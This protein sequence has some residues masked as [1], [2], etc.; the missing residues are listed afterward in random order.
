MKKTLIALLSILLMAFAFT[1]CDNSN[2]G[3]VDD[4]TVDQATATDLATTYMSAINYGSLIVEAF[5]ESNN[6]LDITPEA[7][8]FTIEFDEYKG[9][10]LDTS[11]KTEEN[12][13][14]L[15][16]IKSGALRFTFP[17]T[18]KATESRT[19]YTVETVEDKPLVF[20]D[21]EN[22][23]LAAFEFSASGTASASFNVVGG[24]IVGIADDATS[25]SISKPTE[26]SISVGNVSV[27][28][29]DIKAD[30]EIPGGGSGTTTPDETFTETMARNA[31]SNIVNDLSREKLMKAMMA[32]LEGLDDNIDS[33]PGVTLSKKGVSVKYRGEENETLKKLL[34]AVI[35]SDQSAL[36]SLQ[37][38]TEENKKEL[39][40]IF[41]NI[42]D[43]SI[44]MTVS[45]DYF[46][47]FKDETSDGTS[48]AADYADMIQSG[49]A[50]L[51]IIP[52]RGEFDGGQMSISSLE[53]IY[54][55]SVDNL[56]VITK[57]DG[58]YTI[59]FD[60]FASTVSMIPS[61]DLCIPERAADIAITVSNGTE[62]Q[63]VN[64]ADLTIDSNS[65]FAK[66][67]AAKADAEY[68]YQHFGTLR[69]LKSMYAVFSEADD[70]SNGLSF[71]TTGI[72]ITGDTEKRFTLNLDLN[73]YEYYRGD[74]NQRASGTVSITFKG[75]DTVEDNI[76]TAT[77]FSIGKTT[78]NLSDG[79][80]GTGVRVRSDA[81][82]TLSGEGTIGDEAATEATTATTAEEATKGI[83]FT[84]KTEGT[85]TTV[86]GI[87]LYDSAPTEDEVRYTQETQEFVFNRGE[88]PVI[89][90]VSSAN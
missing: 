25:I 2:S 40:G 53:G 17:S 77:S 13:T 9:A 68:F 89:S 37:S 66:V 32:G 22:K 12:A 47:A 54:T 3:Q 4:P 85:T 52:G 60:D 35:T 73:D 20:V 19:R 27:D 59:S 61:P 24:M 26:A 90:L 23:E 43:V 72:G 34:L 16:Q 1:A 87:K 6:A 31:V 79:T 18:A 11:D 29:D 15:S 49:T 62:T 64:W 30:V 50:T 83:Q 45:F 41:A 5:E 56:K 33:V 8:G 51:T 71:T 67:S 88:K 57:N 10:A 58:V 74:S 82:V 28:F 7:N 36:S 14:E 21:K 55:V 76:F 38:L 75:N 42:Y 70:D 46:D 84:T 80:T 86:T 78:I 69:F 81:T 48:N 63:E 44:E 65:N 39:E